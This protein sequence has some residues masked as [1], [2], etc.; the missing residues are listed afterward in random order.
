MKCHS[1]I[2]LAAA[3]VAIS[4]TGAIAGN[5]QPTLLGWNNLGM[6]CMDDHRFIR[7]KATR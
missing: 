7:L 1:F 5:G 2:I 4:P 3:L 6:H